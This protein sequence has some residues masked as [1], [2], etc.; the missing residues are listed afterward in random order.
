MTTT[1][2]GGDS[3][4][5]T[6][7]RNSSIASRVR[8]FMQPR[9][10]AP[11][12]SACTPPQCLRRPFWRSWQTCRISAFGIAVV[13]SRSRLCGRRGDRAAAP[14]G[15]GAATSARCR[16]RTGASACFRFRSQVRH[17]AV[18]VATALRQIQGLRPR[19]G[20]CRRQCGNRR[21]HRMRH[22]RDCRQHA[23]LH[24]CH[25]KDDWIGSK[26]G[27]A[28]GRFHVFPGRSTDSCN[29]PAGARSRNR[30]KTIGIFC[31]ANGRILRI[32]GVT[33]SK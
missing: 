26:G 1:S 4:R 2:V 3:A 19:L 31:Q 14:R 25:G 10:A 9:P 5:G 13:D 12:D 6:R 18:T 32:S 30:H 21:Q 15:S 11:P 27:S 29:L 22:C 20:R 33:I 16:R 8:R 28:S 17:A 24:K 7:A 23:R